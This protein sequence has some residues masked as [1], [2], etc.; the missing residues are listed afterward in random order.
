VPQL[1][2]YLDQFLRPRLS[3]LAD[4]GSRIDV[5]IDTGLNGGL[6]VGEHTALRIGV[7]L[8]PLW[9]I[10]TVA[11]GGPTVRV[12]EGEVDLHWIVSPPL[13]RASVFIYSPEPN[14]RRGEPEGLLGMK[15]IAP[16]T[17]T[18]DC[19]NLDVKIES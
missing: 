1:H 16:G 17:L 19:L 7:V 4:N 6:F 9:H 3:L 2:G 12:Q 14:H 10:V 18:I 5:L 8:L 15:L 11:G 13:R